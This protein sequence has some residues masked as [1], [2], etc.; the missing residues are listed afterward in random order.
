MHIHFKFEFVL[1]SGFQA[2]PPKKNTFTRVPKVR[3]KKIHFLGGLVCL[4]AN[5]CAGEEQSHYE[6]RSCG[7]SVRRFVIQ[8]IAKLARDRVGKSVWSKG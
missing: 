5:G 4:V 6:C 7:N 3:K 2:G 1:V 8:A